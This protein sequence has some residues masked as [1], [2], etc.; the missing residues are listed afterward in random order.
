M[1]GNLSANEVSA[2]FAATLAGAGISL[3]P[4]YSALPYLRDGTLRALL[5]DYVPREMTIYGVYI[6]RKQMPSA[7]RALLDDLVEQFRTGLFEDT[8]YPG[9]LPSRSKP[10]A[11]P[12]PAAPPA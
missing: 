11:P 10:L 3:Q 8:G 1:G 7:L 5:P 4:V 9:R 12:A 6:S 2:V